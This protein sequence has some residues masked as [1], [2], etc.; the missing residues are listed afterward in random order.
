MLPILSLYGDFVKLYYSKMGVLQKGLKT[1]LNMYKYQLAKSQL[2]LIISVTQMWYWLLV[3]LQ[4]TPPWKAP[5]HLCCSHDAK[6]LITTVVSHQENIPVPLPLIKF[7][8]IVNLPQ[9]HDTVYSNEKINSCEYYCLKANLYTVID[10]VMQSRVN[11]STVVDTRSI[12]FAKIMFS[13]LRFT[14]VINCFQLFK[15]NN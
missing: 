9:Q 5:M 2:N 12:Q 8:Q 6:K 15:L 4:C 10:F 1:P 14:K 7:P 11:N 3:N 13:N